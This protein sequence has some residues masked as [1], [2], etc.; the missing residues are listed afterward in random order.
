MSTDY[1]A[2]MARLDALAARYAPRLRVALQRDC[3]AAVAAA[4]AGASPA[5]A[6]AVAGTRFTRAVLEDL[7]V[8]SGV[9]EARLQY[10][11]LT[12]TKA[13]APAGL[14]DVWTSRLRRFISTEGALSLRGIAAGTR[15]IVVRVLTQAAEA[16]QGVAEAARTLRQQVAELSQARAVSICRTE[17]ISASNYGSLLGAEATGV[18][19]RKRWIAT[20]GPR[21]RPTHRAADGQRVPLAGTFTVGGAAARY[22]GDPL[23]P[24][25][26]RVRC[27][28]AIGFEPVE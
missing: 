25:S 28:C 23:L 17:L 4:E 3:E 1:A 8:A 15:A 24:A 11:A 10:D 16:G 27:R 21:T 22:P 26:E 13:E 19:L 6:A 20:V 9:A 12:T 7:Y 2:R 5:V 18:K 14:L